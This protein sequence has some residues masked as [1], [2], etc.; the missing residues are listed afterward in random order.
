[1]KEHEQANI[2]VTLVATLRGTTQE[3]MLEHEH[4]I[5]EETLRVT[6]WVTMLGQRL[7][8]EHQRLRLTPCM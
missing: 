3:L 1:M 8:L 7:G 4:Q 5:T 2:L 6:S